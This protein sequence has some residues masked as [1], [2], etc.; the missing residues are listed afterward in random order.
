MAPAS[1]ELRSKRRLRALHRLAPENQWSVE[2]AIDWRATLV[3]PKW[4]SRRAYVDMVSQLYHAK[5]VT[6]DACEE[7]L[8]HLDSAEARDFVTTQ[9]SD[10]DRH[11]LVYL[12]YLGRLGDV[13]DANDGLTALAEGARSWRGSPTGLL[14][15]FH[16]V[17]EGEAV[18]I[19]R[20]PGGY[21]PP[22]L[23]PP[24]QPSGGARRSPPRSLWD[25]LSPDGIS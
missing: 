3:P 11:S 22:P 1:D 9:I 18:G 8:G 7:I 13:T 15:A 14:V 12:Q 10:E 20:G 25:P 6:R 19:Q 4:L 17:L 23:V 21:L 16:V 5:R 2:S 24:N